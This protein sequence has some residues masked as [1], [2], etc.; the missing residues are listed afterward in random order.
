M[1]EVIVLHSGERIW[2]LRCAGMDFAEISKELNLSTAECVSRFREFQTDLIKSVSL[3]KREQMAH[4]EIARIDAIQFPQYMAALAGDLKAAEFVLKA[5][6]LRA[7]LAQ[8]DAINPNVGENRTQ[9]L[10][11]GG[12]KEEYLAALIEGRTVASAT[13]D[14]EGDEEDS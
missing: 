2:H 9:I 10:I 12:T 6:A 1:G 13:D 14:D 3:D 7:R 8:L 4:L 5:I 11:A